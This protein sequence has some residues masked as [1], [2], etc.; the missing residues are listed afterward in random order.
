MISP[1]IREP[2]DAGP[3]QMSQ[4]GW[5]EDLSRTHG[6]GTQ[7]LTLLHD[8]L[9]LSRITAGEMQLQSERVAVADLLR[10]LTA[11]V[12]PLLERHRNTLQVECASGLGD[13][14][15]DRE[16]LRQCLLHLLSNAA[17]FTD[18]GML[19]LSALPDP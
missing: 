14:V 12:Q 15:T 16:R 8:L 6:A 1:S 4:D 3:D 17:K 2:T 19:I 10:E 18:R 11:A 7:L 13:M 5:I 9:D